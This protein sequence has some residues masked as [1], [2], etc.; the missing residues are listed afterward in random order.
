MLR[1]ALEGNLKPDPASV[2]APQPEAPT[3]LTPIPSRSMERWL[4][5][6]C[7][8]PYPTREEI[9]RA[10]KLEA[11]HTSARDKEEAERNTTSFTPL[12]CIVLYA[13]DVLSEERG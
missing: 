4:G 2:V 6:E 11:V 5:D 1:N 10:S 3:P 12:Y 7:S 9:M 13:Q 8:H